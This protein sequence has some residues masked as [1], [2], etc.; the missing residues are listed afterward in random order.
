MTMVVVD[1]NGEATLRKSVL[2]QVG[3]RAGDTVEIAVRIVRNRNAAKT[4]SWD[5][6][7]GILKRPDQPVLTI[8]EMND[9]IAEGWATS[10]MAGLDDR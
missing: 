10:G 5:D 8:E 4:K 1:A 9:V 6:L 7:V 2:E 3:A